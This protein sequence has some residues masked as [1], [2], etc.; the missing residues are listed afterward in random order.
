MDDDPAGPRISSVDVQWDG[1]FAR[2]SLWCA[3]PQARSGAP[4]LSEQMGGGA[5]VGCNSRSFNPTL[6]TR[7]PVDPLPGGVRHSFLRFDSTFDPSSP[8]FFPSPPSATPS[9]PYPTPITP[10]WLKLSAVQ[11]SALSTPSPPSPLALR[12]S[13]AA[14]PPLHRRPSCPPPGGYRGAHQPAS[15]GTPAA[16]WRPARRPPAAAVTGGAGN[17]RGG[18]GHHPRRR[19]RGGGAAGGLCVCGGRG[20]RRRL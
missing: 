16:R 12:T 10:P 15:T 9:S 3:A 18:H 2:A 13:W 8:P 6:L 20:G 7:P 1:R 14:P 11:P 19:G 5:L 4:A 17:G